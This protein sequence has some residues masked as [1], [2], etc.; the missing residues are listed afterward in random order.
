MDKMVKEKSIMFI[1]PPIVADAVFDPIRASQPIGMWHVASYLANKGHNV[2]MLDAPLEG[3]DNKTIIG[4]SESYEDFS[5]QKMRDFNSMSPQEFLSEYS[6]HDLEGN[7]NRT[8][9]RVGSSDEDIRE[10][11]RDANPDYVGIAAF[12]TSNHDGVID[13]AKLVKEEC[14][15][16]TIVTGGAHS[17]SMS[18]RLLRDSKGNIDYAVRGDGQY[19]LEEIINGGQPTRGVAF[20]E[21]DIIRDSGVSQRLMSPDFTILNPALLEHINLPMPATHTQDTKGKK[22][23]DFMAS[24]GCQLSCS[25]CVAADKSYIFD[26]SKHVEEQLD[27]L[28]EYGY[29]ELVFQDDDL[30]RDPD[31]FKKTLEMVASKGFTWQD[32]GGVGIES[33]N[34]EIANEIMKYGN[35]TALYVPFNPRNYNLTHPVERFKEKFADNV[36]QLK[37]LRESGIYVYTS[38]IFGN[39]KQTEVDHVGEIKRFGDLISDGYVDQALTFAVSHLPGTRNMRDFGHSIQNPDDLL[40]YSIFVPHTNT[41]SM[42]VRDIEKVVIE[43]NQTYNLLQKEAGSWG[44]AFPK[45]T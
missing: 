22:Y 6:P 43:A 28:R 14:P 15:N 19:V 44:S 35:C 21:G 9:V 11:V 10:R 20:L 4:S 29:Q 12:S 42:S 13:L 5:A 40:G 8:V 38:G 24:R 17:T 23:V 33:L 16:A 39:F 41:G 25:F 1:K 3:M 32:N 34:E 18:E 2:S 30:L 36:A 37:R 27:L 31:H 7:V 45:I 26:P